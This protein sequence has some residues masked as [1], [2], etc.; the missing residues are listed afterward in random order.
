MSIEK[1]IKLHRE[2]KNY[3]FVTIGCFLL[4]LADV[5]FII[6][7]RIVNGGIDSLAI[8]LEF[9]F[10]GHVS[11]NLT[12]I[13]I[14]A[15]QI[16][17]WI[18]GLIFLGRK[19]SLHTLYGTLMFPLFYSLLLRLDLLH[20]IGMDNFYL[21][22]TNSDGSLS[23]VFLLLMGI[24]GGLLSGMGVAFSYLGDGSTGGFDVI[25]FIIAKYT[26]VKE[27]ISG[28]IMDVSFIIIGLCLFHSYELALVGILSAII[29]AFMIQIMYVSTQNYLIVD[30]ISKKS[31]AIIEYIHTSLKRGTTIIDSMGGYS[32]TKQKMVEVIITN[33]E[34]DRLQKFIAF[35]DPHAF[36]SVTEAKNVKGNG[37]NHFVLSS[38]AKKEMLKRYGVKPKE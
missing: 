7:S 36:M 4:A 15:S 23:L 3:L 37:F 33:E 17:L 38:R 12:D 11:F 20:L 25:S 6:P 29:C 32:K 10:K 26:K 21:I 1:K 28:L 30:V 16:L 2:I 35:T 19:F 34:A 27:D 8:I 18:I 14:G 22:Y 5:L 24:F 9:A 13:V 31:D